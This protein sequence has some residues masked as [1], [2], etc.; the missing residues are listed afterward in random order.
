MNIT[1]QCKYSSKVKVFR[2]NKYNVPK[3]E[4]YTHPHRHTCRPEEVMIKDSCVFVERKII[5]KAGRNKKDQENICQKAPTYVI[6]LKELLFNQQKN[7]KSFIVC[8]TRCI[9]VHE[10]C[11]CWS[12]PPWNCFLPHK[13]VVGCLPDGPCGE[14]PLIYRR[15]RGWPMTIVK[16][17]QQN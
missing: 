9:F 6:C 12:L 4:A 14:Q 1:K 2:K 5:C 11:C 17:E 8:G 13:T 15:L 16:M 7:R 3:I 10:W